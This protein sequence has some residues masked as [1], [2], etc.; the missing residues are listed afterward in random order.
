MLKPVSKVVHLPSLVLDSEWGSNGLGWDPHLHTVP[1]IPGLLPQHLT[2][3][4]S[5]NYNG[6][7]AVLD[8]TENWFFF[9]VVGAQDI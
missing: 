7:S 2:T 9:S 5:W 4:N 8:L 3:Y 1:V 6:I